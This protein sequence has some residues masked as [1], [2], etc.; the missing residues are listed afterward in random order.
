VAL[1][2]RTKDAARGLAGSAAA[3]AAARDLIAR[4]SYGR[5]I[6]ILRAELQKRRGDERLRLQL[7]DTLALAGRSREAAELLNALADDLALSGQAGKAI[8]ALKR[9]ERIEPGRSDVEEKLSYLIAHRRRPSFDPWQQARSRITAAAASPRAEAD[10]PEIGME[11]IGDAAVGLH[12]APLDGP[13]ADE[14]AREEIVSLL[15]QVLSPAAAAPETEGA[16]PPPVVASPLF[17]D[18][19][20]QEVLEVIRGLRL[21][22]YEPGEIVVSAGEPGDSMFLITTGRVRAYMKDE[23]GRQR[24]VREMA[25]GD[26]F[27]EISLLTGRPRSATITAAGACELL[28]FDRPALDAIVGRH[29]RVNEVLQAFY[30][31]RASHTLEAGGDAP[32]RD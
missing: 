7:A 9:I 3:M 20:Q 25:E 17:Q 11:E 29:P 26:F 27:G 1:F 14:A 23:L 2:G 30:R 4:R 21:C 18:F 15:G 28:E 13:L 19:S 22:S 10:A 24:Q 16:P 6:E 12:E 32:G 8:A 5:A 31:E